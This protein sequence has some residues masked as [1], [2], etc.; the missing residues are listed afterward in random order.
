MKISPIEQLVLLPE[1]LLKVPLR[2]VLELQNPVNAAREIIQESHQ[3][4]SDFL[5]MPEHLRDIFLVDYQYKF[6][7]LSE[8][9]A[10][11]VRDRIPNYFL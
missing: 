6:M 10:A 2:S 5:E 11:K 9:V 3:R 1:A 7:F 4:Y 8:I